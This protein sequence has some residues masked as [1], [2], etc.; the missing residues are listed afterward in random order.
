MFT[1]W[2]SLWVWLWKKIVSFF[3][4]LMW[5]CVTRPIFRSQGRKHVWTGCHLGHSSRQNLDPLKPREVIWGLIAFPLADVGIKS[6]AISH[7]LS[8]MDIFALTML[9]R[10][11]LLLWAGCSLRLFLLVDSF[12]CDSYLKQSNWAQPFN[13]WLQSVCLGQ[14]AE[15]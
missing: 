9:A 14:D 2:L 8:S 15:G 3:K 7:W 11:S 4:F 13:I 12:I 10:L 6:K 5:N 1:F